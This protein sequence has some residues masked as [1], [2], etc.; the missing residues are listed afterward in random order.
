MGNSGNNSA[1]VNNVNLILQGRVRQKKLVK[2]Y[3]LYSHRFLPKARFW[4]SFANLSAHDVYFSFDDACSAAEVKRAQGAN[5]RIEE[6]PAAWVESLTH[7]VVISE[8]FS[9]NPCRSL[10]DAKINIPHSSIGKVIKLREQLK[11]QK[12]ILWDTVR[13]GPKT[14]P[15]DREYKIY[16][17]H[18]TGPS[19]PIQ[20]S[21][22]S[23]DIDDTYVGH[24]VR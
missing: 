3:H 19:V 14:V 12:W 1:G 11:N 8:L 6:I 18:L 20:W 4:G 24:L 13:M 23:L 10:V 5:F 9:A 16:K 15:S 7:G 17:S 22:S 2:M 21:T